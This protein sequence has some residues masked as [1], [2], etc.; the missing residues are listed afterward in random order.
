VFFLTPI[1]LP[2]TTKS[3]EQM[4]RRQKIVLNRCTSNQGTGTT[5]SAFPESACYKQGFSTFPPLNLMHPRYEQRNE[6]LEERNGYIEYLAS[7]HTENTG[8]L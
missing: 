7:L 1:A 5:A 3:L 2:P 8:T 6:T 4:S